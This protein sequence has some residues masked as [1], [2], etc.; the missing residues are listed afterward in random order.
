MIFFTFIIDLIWLIYWGSA[1][2]FDSGWAS[3][4]RHFVYAMS[5][6]NFIAKAAAIALIGLTEKDNVK[7]TLPDAVAKMLPS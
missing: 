2:S 7:H 4:I 5:I 6:L 3:G 1:D